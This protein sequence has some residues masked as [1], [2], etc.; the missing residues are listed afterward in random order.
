[1]DSQILS[2]LQ[3]FVDHFI[4][5]FIEIA[6]AD[7]DEAISLAMISVLRIMQRYNNNAHSVTQQRESF[8][9]VSFSRGGL[10][11]GVSEEK[12]DLVDAI[13]FDTA[14]SKKLRQVT[15]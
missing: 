11:D 6:C 15:F 8:E 9:L 12:L 13:V 7:C 2:Q 1:M 3:T 14:V 10:L 5:R 4:S